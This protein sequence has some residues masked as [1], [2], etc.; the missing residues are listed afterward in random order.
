MHAFKRSFDDFTNRHPVL[1]YTL[2][3][4]ILI[5]FSQFGAAKIVFLTGHIRDTDDAMRLV[6]IRD[7]LAGQSWFDLHQYRINAPQGLLMH[8]SRLIDAP[9]A[10]LILF[11]KIF[12]S[13]D[14][15]ERL[16]R[17]LW[18]A[19][20]QL[21]IFASLITITLKLCGRQALFP[22]S[23]IIGF[24]WILSMQMEP[25]RIDHH[26]AQMLL[27]SLMMFV[28]YMALERPHYA[29]LA[30]LAGA[31]SMT[32][33]FET[34]PVIATVAA[35]YFFLWAVKKRN[36]DVSLRNFGISFA[37]STLAFY[38]ATT[39][40]ALYLV[41]VCDAQSYIS[42]ALAAG[43]ELAGFSLAALPARLTSSVQ[44]FSAG[45]LCAAALL[46]IFYIYAQPCFS[47]PFAGLPDDLRRDWLDQVFEAAG[48]GKHLRT[49]FWNNLS[50]LGPLLISLLCAAAAF[51]YNRHDRWRFGLLAALVAIHAALAF[52]HLRMLPYAI[53]F[54]IPAIA[55]AIMSLR[56]K[57]QLVM[58]LLYVLAVP[59]AWALLV[60]PLVKKS[61][62]ESRCGDPANYAE[63]A[64]LPRSL[65]LA[66]I[67][68]GTFLLAHTSH[69]AFG[70]PYHRNV[71]GMRY[72]LATLY[73]LP[74]QALAKIHEKKIDYVVL[75][76][77]LGEQRSID[78]HNPDSLATRLMKNETF[79][80]L[81]K[82]DMKPPLRVWRVR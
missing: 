33:G 17:L 45:I 49:D 76:E 51:Y 34:L 23:V 4:F 60:Q 9:V 13:A 56:A 38:F 70:A 52:V 53:M 69:N 22:A 30:G 24:N 81:V 25:G 19:L 62:P 6:E 41:L 15:A 82:V 79:K 47:G 50:F 77:N 36:S 48:L 7:W 64:K 2:F 26:S 59:A 55:W 65:I 58:A 5:W 61:F 28:T 8:W 29:L 63:L 68:I 71:E 27:C 42:T 35:F 37:A 3:A 46:A 21:G 75:C 18:P 66:P 39:P 40:A 78:L 20:M 43:A 32:I 72:V 1:I 11:F 73:Q 12:T 74:E 54:S 16:A 14:M 67:D 31:L 57:A 80:G 44:R 10:A